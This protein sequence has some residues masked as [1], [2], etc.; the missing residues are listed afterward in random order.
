MMRAT[1]HIQGSG[2]P[3]PF[4]LRQLQH[5]VLLADELHFARAA[6]RA[7]LSQSAFSRSIQGLEKAVGLKLFDR[8]LRQVRTTPAGAQFITRARRLLSSAGNLSREVELLRSGDLGHVSMGAG[9]FSGTTLIPGPLAQMHREHPEVRVRL[10]VND[11][12]TLLQHLDEER[13]DFYIADIRELPVREDCIVETLGWLTGSLYCRADHP[14]AARSGLRI[15]DLKSSRFASVHMPDAMKRTLDE[16]ME[17]RGGGSLALALE[18]ESLVIL[19]DLVLRSDVIMLAF[20]G[21]VQLEVHANLLRRLAVQEFD[22]MG[23]RTP[24]RTELGLVRLKDRTPTPAS[25]LL[26]ALVREESRKKLGGS[27]RPRRIKD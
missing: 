20:P 17:A 15:A 9:P 23:V 14:L 4:D 2:M 7:F 11:W 1:Q 6:K 26:M 16:L 13:I 21:A 18:C 12:R 19:R 5:L 24:L 25:E 22:A 10:D 8:G 3:A 27:R